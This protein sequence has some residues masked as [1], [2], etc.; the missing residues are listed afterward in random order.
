MNNN[1]L[2]AEVVLEP[3]N[4]PCMPPLKPM[5]FSPLHTELSQ[6]LLWRNPKSNISVLEERSTGSV[7]E[8]SG[9]LIF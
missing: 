5:P 6:F 9:V 7:L 3:G 8:E 1:N 4:A 2:E